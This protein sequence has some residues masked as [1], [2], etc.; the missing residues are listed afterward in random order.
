MDD[1][2]RGCLGRTLSTI[3]LV[4]GCVYLLLRI[5]GI[6]DQHFHFQKTGRLVAHAAGS[7]D[8]YLNEQQTLALIGSSFTVTYHN[9]TTGLEVDLT[10]HVSGSTEDLQDL[11]HWGYIPFDY[12][13]SQSQASIS[14]YNYSPGLVYYVTFPTGFQFDTSN[15]NTFYNMRCNFPFT[16]SG[17]THFEMPVFWSTVKDANYS[18]RSNAML[19]TSL[20]LQSFDALRKGSGNS[21]AQA[22]LNFNENIPE[23]K[24]AIFSGFGIDFSNE[25]SFS[26]SSLDCGFNACAIYPNSA[27]LGDVYTNYFYIIVE[28]PVISNYSDVTTTVPHTT[29][30]PYS[31][32]YQVTTGQYTYDLSPLETNQIN[33]INIANE[34]LNYVAGIFDG[35]NIIIQQLDDIYNRM[36]ANGEIPVNLIQAD[37]LHTL[38]SD[39]RAN[40]VNNLTSHT[41]ARIPDAG[42]GYSLIHTL[43]YKFT[44]GDFQIFAVIGGLSLCLLVSEWFLFKGRGG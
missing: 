30:A 34:N 15:Q 32:D 10:A 25:S 16:L 37:P 11:G 31:G 6:I 20:G 43:Y 39:F 5:F 41:T 38:D 19:N 23:D 12:L 13:N 27:G 24:I 17:L 3:A 14:P 29:R 21:H 1:K 44:S 4:L 18:T 22:F 7:T 8:V 42:S 35:V 40:I 28:C 33:Q 9:K 36:V 26:V 2:K